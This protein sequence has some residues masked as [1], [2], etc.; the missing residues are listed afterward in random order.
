MQSVS[1]RIW[2]RITP[3]APPSFMGD[4]VDLVGYSFMGDSVDLVGYLF[5]GDTVAIV[6]QK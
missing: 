5:M 3:R 4:S 2:T 1:S 6:F